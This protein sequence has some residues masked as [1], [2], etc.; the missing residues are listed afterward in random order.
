M[1][2]NFTE[3][4]IDLAD[5]PDAVEGFLICHAGQLLKIRQQLRG[6]HKGLSENIKQLC[7]RYKGRKDDPGKQALRAIAAPR[8][9]F[10]AGIAASENR[11]ILFVPCKQGCD[12][13]L[14][15]RTQE[16]EIINFRVNPG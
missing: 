12:L 4:C 14:M 9:G 2:H 1:P 6:I 15:E 11:V 13:Q 7:F 16:A 10:A 3:R 5:G 8:I